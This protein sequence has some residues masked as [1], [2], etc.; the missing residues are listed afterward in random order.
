[1]EET[2]GQQTDVLAGGSIGVMGDSSHGG[3][4]HPRLAWMMCYQ[5]TR[6]VQEVC[7]KFGISRKTFYKWYKRYQQSKGAS[8]ALTDRSRRPHTFPKATPAE[9]IQILKEAK[10]E[11]GFGQRRLRAYL[12][13]RYHITLSE[14]TIWKLLKK[15]EMA[16]EIAEVR[17]QQDAA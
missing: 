2:Q 15:E 7:R 12:E 3:S 11:T 8:A 9:N 17:G 16:E 4:L 1:M 6:N 10:E 5:E 14:R 13:K